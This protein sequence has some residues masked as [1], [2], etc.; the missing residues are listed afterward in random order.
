MLTYTLII[1]LLLAIPLSSYS[2]KSNPTQNT[3][4]SSTG[5]FGG[6]STVSATPFTRITVIIMLCAA[7]LS[8]S[9]SSVLSLDAG[10]G[11]FNGLIH[12]TNL[13]GTGALIAVI[14]IIYSKLTYVYRTVSTIPGSVMLLQPSIFPL[15]IS[16]MVS[17]HFQVTTVAMHLA[18]SVVV[19]SYVLNLLTYIGVIQLGVV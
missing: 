1:A 6:F 11:L 13:F 7:A 12:A 10:P 2:I 15:I 9:S 3:Y 19:L 16:I 17:S 5:T 14:C 18:I 4:S 8:Y